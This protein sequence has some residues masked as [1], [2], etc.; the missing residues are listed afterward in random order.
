MKIGPALEQG[1]R[2]LRSQ[3]ET[4]S[5]DAQV[6][7]ADILTR[8]RAWVLAHPEAVLTEDQRRRYEAGL[9]ACREGQPLAYVLGWWEFYGRRFRIAPQVLIPRPETE[10]MVEQALELIRDRPKSCQVIDIGTGSGCIAVTLAAEVKNLEI[11][12]AD[13]DLSALS[14]AQVNAEQ[15]G[16]VER[17]RFVCADLLRGLKGPFDLICAN[18]PYI[19]TA[20]L[21]KLRVG[22]REPRRALDGGVDGLAVIRRFIDMLPGTMNGGATVLMEIGD[23]QGRS[24][25]AYVRER[26]DSA[27]VQVHHDLAGRERLVRMGRGGEA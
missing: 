11:A 13:V 20:E 5:L 23:G 1:R 21:Q 8:D 3:S 25:A 17:I 6:L 12:A 4:P 22:E 26:F 27:A 9:K 2:A 14:V 19:P 16:V 24:V 10:L 7:L 15:L 18:L